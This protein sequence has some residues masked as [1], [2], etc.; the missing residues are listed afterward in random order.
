MREF[1]TY[2]EILRNRFPELGRYQQPCTFWSACFELMSLADA[3]F[4]VQQGGGH[5]P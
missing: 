2:A 1:E 5:V 3:M 4:Y